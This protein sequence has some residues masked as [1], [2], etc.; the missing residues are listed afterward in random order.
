MKSRILSHAVDAR[1]LK[2]QDVSLI[3][4]ATGYEPR[5]TSLAASL[6]SEWRCPPAELGRKM[7]LLEF[8]SHRDLSS[9]MGADEFYGSIHPAN[10][11]PVS[12]DDGVKVIRAVSDLVRGTPS[13]LVLVDYSCMSRMIYLSLLRLVHDGLDLVFS[14]SI[15]KYGPAELNYPISAVGIVRSVPGYEGLTFASRPRLHVVGLGYDGL[16]TLALM[17]R[18]E[19]SR[20]VTFWANPGASPDAPQIA[21]DQNELL[22]ARSVATFTMNLRHVTETAEVLARI[23]SEVAATDSVVFVPVGPKPQVLASALAAIDKD[24]CSLI[25]PHLGS[26]GIRDDFP[27]VDWSGE[28]VGTRIRI[29]RRKLQ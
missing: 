20:L 5:C 16:G 7:L 1:N 23:A 10:R 18:L 3:V 15:G 6:L 12:T 22:I 27:L 19:A 24:H 25:A 9:R 8:E 4:T 2:L 29:E 13:P 14:Y 28:L 26:G 17:D 21:R 11:L